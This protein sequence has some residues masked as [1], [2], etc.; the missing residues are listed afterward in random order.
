MK[1]IH[2]ADLH[3][4]SPFTLSSYSEAGKRRAELRNDFSA[5]VSYAKSEKCGLFIIAGDLFDDAYI[6]KDTSE[7][8]IKE[9]S[10]FPECRFV[11]TPGN[12]DPYRANS[13]YYYLEFPENTHIFKS[14][15]IEYVEYPEINTRVYGYAFTS[16]YMTKSPL[17][18]FRAKEDGMIN[19]LV[20]HG[21]MLSPL[22]SYCPIT[23]NEIKSSGMDYVALGHI[24]KATEVK[25]AGKTAYAYCGCIEGR[26]FD[27]TGYKGAFAGE[28]TKESLDIKMVKFS[29]KRYEIAKCDVTGANDFK[30]AERI[31]SSACASYGSDTALRVVL[32]GVT[33]DGFSLSDEEIRL[34]LPKPYYVE[35]RDNTLPL[36]NAE[37]LEKDNTIT[38]AFY[39][40]L[41]PKIKSGDEKERENAIL[42]LKY[43]LKAL[44]G[45]EID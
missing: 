12:H 32:E 20:A 23:E 36:L 16:E 14:G 10:S 15:E 38:G 30:D 26:G 7:M 29:K 28:V 19:I 41:L 5:L 31:I 17:S 25:Y 44:G 11:I 2:C 24:H 13:P 4:D 27:E 1:F 39:R 43:G 9:I 3:L 22:S 35:L 18:G 21:D 37:Y 40:K 33:S 45:R 8:L 6:T 34:I 42:A